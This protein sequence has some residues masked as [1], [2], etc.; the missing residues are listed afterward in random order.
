MLVRPSRAAGQRFIRSMAD[1]LS[2]TSALGPLAYIPRASGKG[3]LS[4][5]PVD[6]CPQR[7]GSMET[8]KWDYA[9]GYDEL[10]ANLI[11][12]LLFVKH[13]CAS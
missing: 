7:R 8:L 5:L 3:H 6:C 12:K 4:P 13:S 9:G 10:N 2:L 1:E 11:N